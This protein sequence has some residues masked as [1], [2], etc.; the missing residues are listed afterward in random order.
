MSL[1]KSYR[2]ALNYAIRVVIEYKA[3]SLGKAYKLLYSILK[4]RYGL[5]SKVTQDCYRDGF[6]YF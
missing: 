3:L 1:M 2:E 5:P 4:E 6:R